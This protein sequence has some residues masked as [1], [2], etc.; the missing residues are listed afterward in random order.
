[1]PRE[2][3]RDAVKK[4]GI[5]IS[6]GAWGTWLY[7]MGLIPGQCPELWNITHHDEVI[8]IAR[9]YIEAGADMVETNSLG[10]NVYKLGHFNL[11]NRVGE[12]NEAAAKISREAAGEDVWVIASVGPTGMMLVTEDITADEMY[13]AFRIQVMALEKGGADAIC[14]ETMSDI[15]EAVI[16]VRAV[17][18]NT[19]CEII[20]TFT[21]DK[22]IRGDYR[23]IMGA[24][25]ADAAKAAI[26][27]GADIIGANCGNGMEDMIGIVKEI[28][29]AVPFAPILVQANAGVPVNVDGVTVFPESPEEMASFT[30]DLIKAGA[31]IIGGCCGTTPAHIASI[32]KA[33]MEYQNG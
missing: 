33:V 21:F 16:A 24:S 14:I 7:K 11:G 22:T 6:D 4:N 17:K 27:A 8:S 15:D 29:K 10:G 18:D 25:P 28:R 13:D 12:I 30:G 1:M 23:T 5:L 26:E 32:K 31:D 19:A 20:C 9:G 2:K 3:I